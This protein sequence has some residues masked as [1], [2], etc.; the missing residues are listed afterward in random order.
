MAYLQKNNPFK[1]ITPPR[2]NDSDKQ[3]Y[4]VKKENFAD[5]VEITRDIVKDA[6]GLLGKNTNPYNIR[7]S[8]RSVNM[9]GDQTYKEDARKTPGN[10]YGPIDRLMQM[11]EKDI[12]SFQ[13]NISDAVS[14]FEGLNF[15]K[16]PGKVISRAYN[17]DMD[18]FKEY[19]EKA[20]ID[21][22]ELSNII[23]AQIRN[24]KNIPDNKI[25]RGLLNKAIKFKINQLK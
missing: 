12:K 2:E 10:A 6:D 21:T 19:L 23:A 13:D 14:E 17:L 22:N 5:A 8:L 20:D 16:N 11:D 3:N 4:A 18:P 1:K 25:V 7:Q 24:D 9:S 15:A